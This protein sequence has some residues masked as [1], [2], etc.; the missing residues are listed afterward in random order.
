MIESEP[1]VTVRTHIRLTVCTA[2][3]TAMND[4]LGV[5]QENRLPVKNI[6]VGPA[7]SE[8]D[9]LSG[10]EAGNFCIQKGSTALHACAA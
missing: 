4:D 8:H 9:E 1:G 6:S 3:L 7:E 5:L 10:F 2:T